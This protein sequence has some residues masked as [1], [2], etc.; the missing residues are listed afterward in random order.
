MTMND[1]W[2]YK[3]KD[4][5]WK[6]A[7]QLLRNLIDCASKGGNYL[8]NVGPTGEGLIPEA[9]V[10]RLAEVGRWIQVNSESIYATTATPFKRLSWG[11]CTKKLAPGGV[12]LYLHVFDWPQDGRLL[13]PGLRNKPDKVFLLAQ[14]KA[15]GLTTQSGPEGLIL[16][17][18]SSAP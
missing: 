11:R 1:S 13:L 3:Q 14:P 18:P 15:K 8:L 5:N 2:G 12:T 6:S 4:L 9:S 10:Q 7:R 17:L 16:E